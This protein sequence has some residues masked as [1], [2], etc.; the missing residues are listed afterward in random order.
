MQFSTDISV[1]L[2]QKLL[3]EAFPERPDLLK[4]NILEKLYA[5]HMLSCDIVSSKREILEVVK[6]D[7]LVFNLK[8]DILVALDEVGGE[9]TDSILNACIEEV[10]L[11]SFDL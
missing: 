7:S 3:F 5:E 4:A 1:P 8:S 9:V 10:I 6:F 2:S 11:L